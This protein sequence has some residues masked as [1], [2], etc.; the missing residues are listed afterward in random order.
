MNADMLSNEK[1]NPV[2]TKSFIRGRKVNISLVFNTKSYFAVLK[3]RL[4]FT[5]FFIMKIPN[6]QELQQIAFNHFIRY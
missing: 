6:K 1:L 4:N 3:N 2:V 5:H